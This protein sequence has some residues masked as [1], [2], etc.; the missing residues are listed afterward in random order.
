M[1]ANE[2]TVEEVS[3]S[4]PIK[5]VLRGR[6]MPYR[7]VST[8]GEQRVKTTWY[9][10]NPKATQQ[11]LGPTTTPT[12]LTGMWK[13]K[14]VSLAASDSTADAEVYN[15]PGAFAISQGVQDS[16][17]A[18]FLVGVFE[19]LRDR[20]KE[21]RFTWG[22]VVRY[23]LLQSFVP[24][25]DRYEDVAWSM[26]FDWNG[27]IERAPRVAGQVTTFGQPVQTALVRSDDAL[28][29]MP[30][31]VDTPI[32]SEILGAMSEVRARVVD[33]LAYS[34]RISG[35]I[36]V[37]LEVIQGTAGIVAEVKAST[38]VVVSDCLAIPY[39]AFI[40]FDDVVDVVRVED[41]RR[42]L[43]SE[44][45][46][47]EVRAI[48]ERDSIANIGVDLTDATTFRV[49]QRTSLRSLAAQYYG[50]AADWTVIAQANNLDTSIVEA[51]QLIYIPTRTT[52][53]TAGPS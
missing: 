16:N 52:L 18:S 42:T 10:G 41:F 22:D 49:Q 15:V 48:Q 37:P 27:V 44:V 6:A 20:G 43:G 14:F 46:S 33:L 25:W 29:V 47:L 11:V 23:G 36:T 13:S 31:I 32:R 21:I 3:G 53:T 40:T 45:E 19:S 8:G 39:E 51:G 9:Q 30:R 5:I 1:S 2:L 24:T 26:T 17:P 4:R 38:T 50:T 28:V 35:Q 7:G 34:R 12:E